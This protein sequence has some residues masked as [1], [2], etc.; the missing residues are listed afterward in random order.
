VR[1]PT[2]AGARS[3]FVDVDGP[4]H[5]LDM[6]GPADGPLIVGLHG[7]G[8]SHLN[9]TAVG[10]ELSGHARVV[11]LDLVGHGLTPTGSRTADLEGH[12]RLV[13]GF[14]RAFGAESTSAPGARPAILMGNSM[15]GL[16]AA[17]QAGEEPDT[18][19]GLVLVDP[20]LPTSRLGLVHPRVVANFLLCALPAVGEQYLTQRR[21]RTT[22]EQTV[23][24]V[25]GVC[26]V[27]PSRVPEHVVE[28]HIELSGRMDRVR[29]D[30]AYL[31]SAR[32]LSLLMA[33]PAGPLARLAGV[34]QPTL[35]LQGARD[36]LVPLASARRMSAA[37]PDWRLEI[38]PDVGHAPMLEAPAW[39][40]RMIRR[41]LTAEGAGAARAAS[42]A[43]SDPTAGPFS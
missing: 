27:D 9:W 30:A 1:A 12:R 39:T 17:L 38:A 41:W 3:R 28:A 24:R 5:F 2:L 35:L 34:A 11:A 6:G 8:G 18:V 37:H 31:R 29:A 42:G 23:R 15:G 21:R 33:L 7:L 10:P 13:S 4:A 32:S 20:A 36:V 16:V 19:A 40:S 25:L 43:A 22:A 26:C 14:L